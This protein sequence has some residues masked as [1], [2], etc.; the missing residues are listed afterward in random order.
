[1]KA[2]REVEE[3]ESEQRVAQNGKRW[4][5][6]RHKSGFE[7]VKNNS[8]MTN[9]APGEDGWRLLCP[10]TSFSFYQWQSYIQRNFL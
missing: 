2:D 6:D 4:R 7:S 3:R 8:K 10:S 5:I 1:M 9:L